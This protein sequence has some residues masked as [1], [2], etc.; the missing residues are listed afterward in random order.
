MHAQDKA[1]KTVWSTYTSKPLTINTQSAYGDVNGVVDSSGNLNFNN[2]AACFAKPSAKDIFSCSTGPFATGSNALVNVIIPRLSAAF[3]R[4][5]LLL[6][7]SQPNGVQVSQYY[8]DAT[9]NVSTGPNQVLML[10]ATA[11]FQDCTCCQPRWHR[12]CIS[13]RRCHARWWHT[14]RRCSKQWQSCFP[15]SLCWRKQCLCSL[16][17][18]QH[19]DLT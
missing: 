1:D 6:S 19:E 14:A 10:T 9:T 4:S 11:L 15:D 7:N 18:Y 2:G 5:T 13:L 12:I 3:H 17:G 16:I 8:Q